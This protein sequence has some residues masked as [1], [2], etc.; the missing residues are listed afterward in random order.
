MRDYITEIRSLIGHRPL[1]CTACGVII[2]NEKGEI[3]LQERADNGNWGLPGGS[4]IIGEKFVETARREVYEETGLAV[5]NLSL[6]GIFSGKDRIIE[7]PNKDICCV[8]SI[9]FITKEYSGALVQ[10]TDE[11][12]QNKFFKKECI[13]SNISEFDKKYIEYWLK[14]NPTII[15]D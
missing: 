1:M 6:F 2:E 9:I 10:Q 13:P 8:T 5:G 11:T 7:Y 3:L 12:K 4:M 15:V 14:G